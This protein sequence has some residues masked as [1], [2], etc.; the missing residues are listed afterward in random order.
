MFN[1]FQMNGGYMKK[2]KLLF[3]SLIMIGCT[4]L[5]IAEDTEKE[6]S[7]KIEHSTSVG[8]DFAYYFPTQKGFGQVGGFLPIS[9][10]PAV[11]PD[12]KD[13]TVGSTWGGAEFQAKIKHGIKIPCLQGENP[14]VA[15][16]NVKFN[17]TG[18]LAPVALYGTAAA[19]LTPI[20]FLN[21][22]VGA[23]VGTGWHLIFNGLGDNDNGEISEKSFPG[24]VIEVFGSG[25][26]QFDLAAVVPGDWNHVVTQVNAKF[27]YKMFTSEMAMDG[28]SWQWLNDSGENLNGWLYKG[29]YFLGYQMPTMVNLVGFLVT[30]EQMIGKN[31]EISPIA[32]VDE[33]KTAIADNG[34]G[35]DFVEVTF[36]PI[37]NIAFNDQHNLTVELRFK[38]GLDY[39]DNTFFEK[40]YKN[41]V[42]EDTYLYF[43]RIGLSYS[44]SF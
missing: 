24:A 21:F 4:V 38:N 30:T 14:L 11:D 29:T 36:G 20:A 22:E 37:A 28:G 42:V 3:L 16:N 5:L 7:G 43:D 44:Y 17:F 6:D 23:T 8:V 34:W 41:K 26:F 39:L 25:T 35:S 32:G 27:M 31:S 18:N 13:N 12:D 19:V 40:Y 33:D 2:I 9:Y 1:N 15:D 10:K